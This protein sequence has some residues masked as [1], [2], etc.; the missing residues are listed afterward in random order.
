M[1]AKRSDG[2]T[3]ITLAA[4]QSYT[5]I[6]NILKQADASARTNINAELLKAA[7]VGNTAKVQQL[8]KQ[9]ANANAA[10]RYGK[11]VL[12]ATH[13]LEA[14]KIADRVFTIQDGRLLEHAPETIG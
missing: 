9:G 5:G 3:A 13:V 12:M 4:Q 10:N 2:Q 6:A 7:E 11:T 8:L 14:A 1:N